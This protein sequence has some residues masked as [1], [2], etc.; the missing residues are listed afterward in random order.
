MAIS[1]HT[2]WIHSAGW[3][4]REAYSLIK[5]C[6]FDGV[7]FDLSQSWNRS[8][9]VSGINKGSVFDGGVD[10]AIEAYKDEIDAIIVWRLDRLTCNTMDFHGVIR[11]FL[12]KYNIKLLSATED[13]DETPEGKLM[14]NITISIAEFEINSYSKRR[15]KLSK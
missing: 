9:I 15:K 12:E 8:E 14:R 4:K 5:D 10:N 2:T 13:N 3:D 7:D 6:G 11:P 1:I